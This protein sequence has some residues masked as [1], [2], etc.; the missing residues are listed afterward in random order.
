[1]GR[2]T[3]LGAR[4]RWRTGAQDDVGRTINQ[5]LEIVARSRLEGGGARLQPND[6]LAHLL[7]TLFEGQPR[8]ALAPGPAA[9]LLHVTVSHA[10]RGE[11]TG[12]A[13][14]ATHG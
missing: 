14:Q 4:D 1:V 8:V 3:R 9:R 13:V 2:E 7:A 5:R 11:P 12:I 10:Q 6:E